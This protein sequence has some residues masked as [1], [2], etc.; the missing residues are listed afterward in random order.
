MVTTSQIIKPLLHGFALVFFHSIQIKPR[1][2]RRHDLKTQ[3][4]FSCE[5][6]ACKNHWPLFK[7]LRAK[8]DEAAMLVIQNL[9]YNLTKIIPLIAGFKI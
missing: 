2:E 7:D 4:F 9:T 3:Y 8:K 6:P 1:D 5:C